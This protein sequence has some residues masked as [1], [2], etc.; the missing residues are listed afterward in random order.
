[1]HETYLKEFEGIMSQLT[2]IGARPDKKAIMQYVIN[3]LPEAYDP[4]IEGILGQ[5]LPTFADLSATLMFEES[6]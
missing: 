4:I 1:M 2:L 3:A 5:G 6:R